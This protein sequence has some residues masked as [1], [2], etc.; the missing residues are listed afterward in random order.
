MFGK[1]KSTAFQKILNEIRHREPAMMCMNPNASQ[2]EIDKN[3][4][5]WQASSLSVDVVLRISHIF[6]VEEL[7]LIDLKYYIV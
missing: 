4:S 1:E 3:N 5:I 2:V 7:V 6:I